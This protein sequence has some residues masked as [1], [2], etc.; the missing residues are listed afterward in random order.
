MFSILFWTEIRRFPVRKEAIADN[1]LSDAPQQSEFTQSI[2]SVQTNLTDEFFISSFSL[3]E[4][5]TWWRKAV[6]FSAENDA[7]EISQ[8]GFHGNSL[9]SR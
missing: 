9:G 1:S 2:T 4:D 6:D 8:A 7:M 5:S 3:V